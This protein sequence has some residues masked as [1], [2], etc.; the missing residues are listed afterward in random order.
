MKID[1]ILNLEI[2]ELKTSGIKEIGYTKLT[3][4]NHGVS[5]TAY[6]LWKKKNSTFIQ[7]FKNSEYDNKSLQKFKP[8]KLTDSFFFSFYKMNKEKLNI[9]NVKHFEY[10][11]DSIVGKENYSNRITISHSC[12][13]HFVIKSGEENFD[14]QFD[15][16]DLQEFD[17]KKE[18]ASKLKYAKKKI[19]KWEERGW[20]GMEYEIIHE[21]YPERNL[22]FEF[23]K[24]SRIV[25]WDKIMTEFIKELEL[26]NKFELIERE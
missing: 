19:K 9:E 24:K 15:Y 25:E 16:F 13:R 23:N 4:I 18:Y 5:S 20:E 8:I 2:A 26:E 22:N 12:F 1:S 21:N 10:K 14:R 7:K 17:Q 11:P 6:L 3:C